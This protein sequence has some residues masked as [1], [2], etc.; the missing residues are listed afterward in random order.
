MKK[1]VSIVIPCF[2]EEE[3]IHNTYAAV[4]SVIHRIDRYEFE[5][6]FV[7]NGSRDRSAALMTDLAVK[8]T[9]VIALILSRNFGPE[10]SSLA[11]QNQASGDAVILMAADLQDPP[12]LIPEFLAKWE[13]G[14]DM[15]L[16]RVNSTRD[17]RFLLFLRRS[18]YKILHRISYIDIPINVT[19]FGL[20]DKKVNQAIIAIP[21]KSRF[22]R[23]LLALA[24]FKQAYVLFDKPE[25]KF[26][27]TSY[28]LL[29][30]LQHAEK[31]LF[32]FTTLP[33]DLIVFFSGA[34]VLLSILVIFVYMIWV[35][36]FSNPITG[37]VTIFLSIMFFGSVNLLA[38]SIVGKYIGIIF[39]ETKNRPHF[40]I[41]NLVS[42]RVK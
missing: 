15:V 35:F 8:E 36:A 41:K 33:L 2:N 5:I 40:F 13:E 9:G 37:S 12:E 24:G 42:K 1:L 27:Q 18:F 28:N 4:R 16:G 21:E 30:Y 26:G 31:G 29:R 17:N 6:I 38:I 25:R 34:L 32:G 19:G 10:I 20:I 14:Y 11:G 23:G 3:N 22:Y 7:D 39:E